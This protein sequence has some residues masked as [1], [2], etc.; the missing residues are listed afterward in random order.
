MSVPAGGGLG[1]PDELLRSAFKPDRAAVRRSLDPQS[2]FEEVPPAVMVAA[3]VLPMR[4]APNFLLRAL[5]WTFTATEPVLAILVYPV[6]A[7][8]KREPWVLPVA[9]GVITVALGYSFGVVAA[10]IFSVSILLYGAACLAWSLLGVALVNELY[11]RD[12]N[13]IASSI[14]SL[15]RTTQQW[16]SN[17]WRMRQFAGHVLKSR[18]LPARM[19]DERAHA[20]SRWL[21]FREHISQAAVQVEDVCELARSNE[22]EAAGSPVVMASAALAE[23]M[24]ALIT[25][26]DENDERLLASA[27][28]DDELFHMTL[29]LQGIVEVAGEQAA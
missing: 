18:R 6:A 27:L 3:S 13:P 23:A 10:V 1:N 24:R 5:S 11:R 21:L 17:Y 2:L 29:R 16:A 8:D 19:I 4:W 25:A 7:L 14:A 9:G 28:D 20:E 26:V 15:A 12:G 22:S